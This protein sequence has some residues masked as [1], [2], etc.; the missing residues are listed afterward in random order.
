MDRANIAAVL[1]TR[2]R[3]CSCQLGCQQTTNFAQL[4]HVR[5]NFWGADKPTT[6]LHRKELLRRYLTPP[7]LLDGRQV[8]EQFLRA[9]LHIRRGR[10]YSEVKREIAV[11]ASQAANAGHRGSLLV[12]LPT[13]IEVMRD[14]PTREHVRA[15]LLQFAETCADKLPYPRTR[16]QVTRGADVTFYRLPFFDKLSCWNEYQQ[17]ML[18]CGLI[19][20]RCTYSYFIRVWRKF[21]PTI[22]LTSSGS[23]FKVCKV[24]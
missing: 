11:A 24:P 17:E 15:W 3:I 1:D 2:I 13:S 21:C 9:A 16:Q 18:E 23:T 14:A 12:Q 7:Y 10:Q 19:Q 8:C 5:E 6:R 20:Y 4:V 22:E